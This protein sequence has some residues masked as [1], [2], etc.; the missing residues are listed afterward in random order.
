MKRNFCFLHQYYYYHYHCY[1]RRFCLNIVNS[2]LNLK[3]QTNH[4]CVGLRGSYY[5]L[6]WV[7]RDV[8]GI[9]NNMMHHTIKEWSNIIIVC[10][11]SSII[12]ASMVMINKNENL[13]DQFKKKNWTLLARSIDWVPVETWDKITRE[14]L[15]AAE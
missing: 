13:S 14:I 4:I 5:D 2:P 12:I 7:V 6:Q 3:Q 9:N 1:Y 15:S 8:K 10:I 11:R